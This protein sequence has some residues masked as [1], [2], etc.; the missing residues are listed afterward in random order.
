MK[1]SKHNFDRIE[2]NLADEIQLIIRWGTS[3]SYFSGKENFGSES[4][5]RLREDL[6]GAFSTAYIVRIS[7]F[8]QDGE[9]QLGAFLNLA[10]KA[11]RID[12]I[13]KAELE[14][15]VASLN[16]RTEQLHTIRQVFAHW[17]KN[18][19]E[20]P[21]QPLDIAPIIDEVISIFEAAGGRKINRNLYE[22]DVKQGWKD[23][24]RIAKTHVP[25]KSNRSIS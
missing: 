25:P 13:K 19:P 23:L 18:R 14:K 20:H 16:Q 4:F 6:I 9:N 3:R 12:V 22:R 10:E 15:A 24:F 7:T 21:A 5:G 2:S 8:F 11:G 1:D 17:R